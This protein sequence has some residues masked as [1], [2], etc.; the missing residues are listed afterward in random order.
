MVKARIL[1][2]SSK[3]GIHWGVSYPTRYLL[4]FNELDTPFILSPNRLETKYQIVFLKIG[5]IGSVQRIYTCG[6][7]VMTI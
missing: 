3:S 7:I 6:V 4:S 5:F 2:N 1:N